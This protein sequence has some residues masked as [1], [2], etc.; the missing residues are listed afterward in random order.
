MTTWICGRRACCVGSVMGRAVGA[1]GCEGASGCGSEVLGGGAGTVLS[2][3]APG[4]CGSVPASAGSQ[5]VC[6]SPLGV[7]GVRIGGEVSSVG[8]LGA[9]LGASAGAWAGAWAGVSVADLVRG[10]AGQGVG[11]SRC[12]TVPRSRSVH[13]WV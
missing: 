3:V 5:W 12:G 1:G 6:G 7:A 9:S 4:L 8:S 13:S 2:V 11:S 10:A